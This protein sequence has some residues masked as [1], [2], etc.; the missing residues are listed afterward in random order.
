V[1]EYRVLG[2]YLRIDTSPGGAQAWL[3]DI[4]DVSESDPLAEATAATADEAV[5]ELISTIT[6]NGEEAV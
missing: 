5:A 6:F 1:G 2:F 4:D 3:Y